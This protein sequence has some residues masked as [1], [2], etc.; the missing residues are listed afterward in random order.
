MSNVQVPTSGETRQH[1]SIS[2]L[3]FLTADVWNGNV[4]VHETAL[5][6][7][8][9]TVFHRLSRIKI[10]AAMA[11]TARPVVTVEESLMLSNGKSPLR[12]SQTPSKSMPRFLPA[13]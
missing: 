7:S 12:I 5:H 10:P 2:Q 1:R 9:F 4:A 3:R 11:S 8:L 6:P 13:K